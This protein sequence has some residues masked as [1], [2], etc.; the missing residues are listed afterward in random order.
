MKLSLII[1]ENFRYIYNRLWYM[2]EIDNFLN[3]VF[4]V[5]NKVS[6]KDDLHSELD[7]LFS[8]YNVNSKLYYIEH[9]IDN[10][11]PF[12]KSIKINDINDDILPFNIT[13]MTVRNISIKTISDTTVNAL[14]TIIVLD[15][16]SN[17]ITIKFSVI[18][19]IYELYYILE[20]RGLSD[21]DIVNAYKYIFNILFNKIKKSINN[22]NNECFA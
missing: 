1:N 2:K 10:K 12:I 6:S 3:Q 15:K 11:C 8:L 21:I 16:Y 5:L 17:I 19:P 18:I 4:K 22:N 14:F 13:M 9:D 7:N 20:K